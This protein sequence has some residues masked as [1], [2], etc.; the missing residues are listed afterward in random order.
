MAF[1][2]FGM[3]HGSI[4]QNCIRNIIKSGEIAEKEN[5]IVER[6]DC[7]DL[8]ASKTETELIQKLL[9]F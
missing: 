9:T 6:L 5:V 7:L 3:S 8:K 1:T 2:F 4:C